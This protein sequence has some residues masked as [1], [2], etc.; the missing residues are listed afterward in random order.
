[1]KKKTNLFTVPRLWM[2]RHD[3][4]VEVHSVATA[5]LR[6]GRIFFKTKD[7]KVFADRE[8]NLIRPHESNDHERRAFCR[9]AGVPMA[10]LKEAAKDYASHEKHQQAQRTLSYVRR[11]ASRHGYKL[12]KMRTPKVAP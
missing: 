6:Q 2:G 10:A 8:V 5:Q 11:V 1:M 4:I 12:T 9:L 3:D 7:G